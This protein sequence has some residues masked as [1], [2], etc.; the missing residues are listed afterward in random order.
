[1]K[2]RYVEKDSNALSNMEVWR[3]KYTDIEYFILYGGGQLIKVKL[4]NPSHVSLTSEDVI[5]R[6]Y[7][8]VGVIS[9]MEVICQ[10]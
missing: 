3:H 5:R 6:D 8:Y 2:I 9:E 7:K 4:N 10:S 1:M